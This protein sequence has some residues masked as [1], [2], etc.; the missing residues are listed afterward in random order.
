MAPRRNRNTKNLKAV[1][2]VESSSEEE[3]FIGFKKGDTIENKVWVDSQVS[4]LE[5]EQSFLDEY[6][7]AGPS[8][9]NS[10][11]SVP[12]PAPHKEGDS[13]IIIICEENNPHI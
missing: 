10:D 6:A 5:K 9:D 12:I 7:L 11:I 1:R 13:E 2:V 8:T 4:I 3:G